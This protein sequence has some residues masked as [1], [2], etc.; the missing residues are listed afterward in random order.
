MSVKRNA[1]PASAAGRVPGR[2]AGALTACAALVLAASCSAGSTDSGGANAQAK[3]PVIR[4]AAG[5]DPA[6][7]PLYL[8][9]QRGMFAKAGVNVQLMQTEGGP[10]AAQAVIAGTAQISA[11]ADSTA[12]SLMANNA[13]LRALGV[14]QSS[15]RYLKVVLRKGVDAPKQ[16]RTMGSIQ[17]IGLYATHAYLKHNGIDPADVKIAKGSPP[18]MPGLLGRGSIDGYILFEPWAANGVKE[19]GH[20]AGRIGD[21]GVG[22]VQWLLA[23]Q[24]WLSGHDDAAGKIFKVVAEA[25]RIVAKDPRAAAEATRRQVKLPVDATVKV[26]PE[27]DFTARGFT[28]ADYASAGREL[29]F[30]LGQGLIKARPDLRTVMVRGWYERYAR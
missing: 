10:T 18:D 11:N 27:I 3:G 19:G 14:F 13:N 16:I 24:K 17:G 12:L 22:Y 23:D 30:L 5:V 8:A 4:I 6:Y 26:L 28:D 2:A 25:D 20:I 1:R 21:F 15:D 29:D 7:A 9:V